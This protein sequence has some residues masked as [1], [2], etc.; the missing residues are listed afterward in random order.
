MKKGFTLIE[1]L[2]VVAIIAIL[3]AIAVPNFLEAQTRSKISRTKAD[4][5]SLATGIEAYC[6]DNNRYPYGSP[7]SIPVPRYGLSLLSTPIAY[8]T[9]PLLKDVFVPNGATKM[10]TGSGS[11]FDMTPNDYGIKYSLRGRN[12]SNQTDAGVSGLV[13]GQQ[14][15]W[16]ILDSYGPDVDA[17]GYSTPI[18]NNDVPATCNALYDASNGTISSGEILRASGAAEKDA[19]KL[20]ITYSAK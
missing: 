13:A 11:E 1:L 8:I 6:V 17:D 4:M 14:G 18:V 16:W 20:V 10:R 3:A 2:I 5:R 9:N 19:G 15:R 12:T 7:G